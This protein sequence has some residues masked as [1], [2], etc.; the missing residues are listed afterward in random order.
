[1]NRSRMLPAGKLQN[2]NWRN[3]T[4]SFVFRMNSLSMIEKELRTIFRDLTKSQHD[5]TDRE[6][7]YRIIVGKFLGKI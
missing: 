6:D 3:G 1:M 5:L 4:T 2:W 7:R